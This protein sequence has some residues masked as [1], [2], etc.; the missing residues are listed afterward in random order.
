MRMPMHFPMNLPEPASRSVLPAASIQLPRQPA[1]S[2]AFSHRPVLPPDFQQI[3]Y[4][5][6]FSLSSVR[7]QNSI[8]DLRPI[9][10]ENGG[11]MSGSLQG[12][13]FRIPIRTPRQFPERPYTRFLH[14]ARVRWPLR[15]RR[16]SNRPGHSSEPVPAKLTLYPDKLPTS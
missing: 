2:R 1:P 3:L 7:E 5:L 14:D 10:P 15:S 13:S 16:Q 6:T 12:P 8:P 9:G 11:S 4:S